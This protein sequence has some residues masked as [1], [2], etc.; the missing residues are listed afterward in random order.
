MSEISIDRQIAAVRNEIS[1]RRHVYPRWVAGGRMTQEE[2][3]RRIAEMEAV[4]ETLERLRGQ[5]RPQLPGFE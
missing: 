3:D 2:A 5:E 4:R 1:L